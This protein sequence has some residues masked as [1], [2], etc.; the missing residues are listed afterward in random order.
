MIS[1]SVL[2]L[3]LLVGFFNSTKNPD[4]PTVKEVD[5][6]KYAGKWYEIAKLPNRFERGLEC[7]TATYTIKKNG[8]VEV[9]NGGIKTK[10]G[11]MQDIKGTAWVPN[12]SHPGVLKVQFFW[13]FAG[14]YYIMDLDEDYQYALVGSPNRDYLWILSRVPELSDDLYISLLNNAKDQ[15]FDMLL[16]LRDDSASCG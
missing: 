5:L 7:I 15:G 4:L 16:R 9:K 8:K 12:L 1:N 13:P 2:G 14:D 6:N 10:K 11:K 3:A